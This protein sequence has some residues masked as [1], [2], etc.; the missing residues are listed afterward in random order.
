MAMARGLY[1]LASQVSQS[2]LHIRIDIHIEEEVEIESGESCWKL[3]GDS[4]GIFI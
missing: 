1:T 3:A 2:S 4:T